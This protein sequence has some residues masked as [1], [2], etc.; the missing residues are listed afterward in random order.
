L[1]LGAIA[2]LA[3][4]AIF[5]LVR[6]DELSDPVARRTSATPNRRSRATS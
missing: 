5:A 2:L 6:R 4:S 1:V 3:I